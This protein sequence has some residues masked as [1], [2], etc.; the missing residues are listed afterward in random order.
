MTTEQQQQPVNHLKDFRQTME[1]ALRAEIAKALPKDIDPDRFIR[2]TVTAVQMNQDL[3]H[4]ERKSL[5]AACMRAAQDGLMPDGREAV[6]NIYN[7]KKRVWVEE[8]GR[9]EERWI[10]VVQYLPMVRGLLKTMRNSGEIAHL[11]AAAVYER[12]EFTFE[13]G[14]SP[15]LVHKP[16]LGDDDAGKIIAA[17]I[18]VRLNNGE[19]HREVMPRRDIEKTRDASKSGSGAS[20]PWTK[21]YDQM[22]IKAVIKRAYKLLPSSSDRLNQVIDHDN[23]AMGFDSFNQRGLDATAITQQAAPAALTD[24]RAAQASATLRPSRM[25]G[26]VGKARAETVQEKPASEAQQAAAGLPP[27]HAP[28]DDEPPLWDDMPNDNGMPMA[29]E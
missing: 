18:V 14:D 10:P 1:G 11:D 17:Y 26:I 22:A 23:E 24:Q 9:E 21:W 28:H 4:A 15:K 25:A 3:L 16:Y 5:L 7:T 6:L 12:D 20:S 2:T 13:R 8:K 29:A 19:I 27:E